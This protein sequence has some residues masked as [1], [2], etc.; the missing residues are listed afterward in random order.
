[1]LRSDKLG[2][3]FV[4]RDLTL[5]QDCYPSMIHFFRASWSQ[6]PIRCRWFSVVK[7]DFPFYKERA[8]SCPS[9]GRGQASP[10]KVDTCPGLGSFFRNLRIPL[11]HSTYT[12]I[13]L[14]VLEFWPAIRETR[15][16]SP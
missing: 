7:N 11:S 6:D 15:L 14:A 10:R 4:I 9:W 16:V 8:L 1:M 2:V 3:T 12:D 13:C 5:S